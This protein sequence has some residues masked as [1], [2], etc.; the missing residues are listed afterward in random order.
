VSTIKNLDNYG[1]RTYLIGFLLFHFCSQTITY[2]GTYL[3]ITNSRKCLPTYR[4][5]GGNLPKH[6]SSLYRRRKNVKLLSSTLDKRFQCTYVCIYCILYSFFF[7]HNNNIILDVGLSS[8]LCCDEY[9][10]V[11]WQWTLSSNHFYI[12]RRP[13]FADVPVT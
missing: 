10:R 13:L 5:V 11:L 12:L 8:I 9:T 6:R 3:L 1:F 4:C 7:F 2:M